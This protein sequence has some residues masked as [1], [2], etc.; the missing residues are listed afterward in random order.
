[1]TT[2]LTGIFLLLCAGIFS[3][4]GTGKKLDAANAQISD[5][6]AKNS[7]L[8]TENNQLTTTV[9]ELKKQADD[10]TKKNAAS[11]EQFASYQKTCETCQAQL[12]VVHDYLTEQS[13]AMDRMMEK[14]QAG[15]SEFQSHGLDVYEKNGVLHV[16][17]EDA[18]L[19]KSGSAAIS[20]KGKKAVGNLASVLG[21]FP[22]LKVT[23]VGNTDTTHVKGVADNWSLSTERANGI[24]R[25]LTKEYNLNPARFTSAGKG[26]FSPVADNA[27]AE[28]RAKNRRTEIVINPNWERIWQNAKNE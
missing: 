9:N 2:K 17:M 19:Y 14:L 7:Q 24:I 1:M 15:L 5:L 27:T 6:Q 12:K 10:L 13:Q 22:D 20:Q 25:I 21:E 11:M 23:V 3:S 28:G 18:L 4:C 26:K 16:D 8:V